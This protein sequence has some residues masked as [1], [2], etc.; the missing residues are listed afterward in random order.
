VTRHQALGWLLVGQLALCV[1]LRVSGFLAIS[2]DDYARVVIAQRF[3]GGPSWDPSGSS[4]LPLPFLLTGSAMTLFGA[5]LEVARAVAVASSLGAIVLLYAAA[6]QLSMSRGF[7]VVTALLGAS[8]PTL[9]PLAVAT[10]PEYWCAALAV[11]GLCTLA[12]NGRVRVLGALALGA[13]T[14]C[15]YETW[16]LTLGF[17]LFCA[18]DARRPSERRTA[19]S[20]AVVALSFPA[21]WL[22]HGA[23]HHGS[24]LFFV[25]R[26]QNY[27][28][29]LGGDGRDLLGMWTGYPAALF[30][31]EPE[32]VALVLCAALAARFARGASPEP[33]VPTLRLLFP[34]ALALVVLVVG[35]VRGGAPT[36]HPERALLASWLVL[37]LVA[38]TTVA[39]LG[40]IRAAQILVLSVALALPFRWSLTPSNYGPRP[41]EEEAGRLVRSRLSATEKV[42]LATS[43]YG[44]FAIEA[45]AGY[46]ERF[47]LAE[48]HDPRLARSGLSLAES[49][50]ENARRA[51]ACYGLLPL[52]IEL[53]GVRLEGE[54]S[55]FKLVRFVRDDCSHNR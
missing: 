41:D 43:D 54:S 5:T 39:R 24:A 23:A 35:D 46:P 7:A 26:V 27:K 44:Y 14:A 32:L 22:A 33:R 1:W 12:R 9:R 30:T 53:D 31:R 3:V 49:L 4:W 18:L 2:D 17:A 16:P 21:A 8:L 48:T 11:F 51:H 34:C 47:V 20:A 28:A 37:L 13:A 10:V 36:H 40:S 25:A 29:A 6:R 19:L 38:L 52:C 55:A 45:T 50:R 42:A 15:R